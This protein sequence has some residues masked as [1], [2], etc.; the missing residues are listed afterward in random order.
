VY[1]P[2]VRVL[3]LLAIALL[4]VSCAARRAAEIEGELPNDWFLRQR[5]GPAGQIPVRARSRALEAASLS[6]SAGTWSQ[7]GP[8]NIGGRIAALAV[9]PNDPNRI[10]LG[11][12]EGGVF[13]SADGGTTWTPKFDQQAV[14]PVGSLAVH[15]TNSSIVY[16]GTGEEGA[17]G[18]SYEGE[19]VF[20][21]TDGGASWTDMG[22][23]EVRRIAKIAIDPLDPQRLFVA[24]GGGAFNK[25]AHRG[26]YRTTD[27]GASWEKVLY[28]ADDSGAAD[29][30]INPVD[31][32]RVF[33]AIW[34]RNRADNENYFGGE[35]S[36]IYR[37]LDGGD[38]WAKLVTGLPTGSLGRIGLAIAPSNP[39]VVYAIIYLTSGSLN[40]IWRSTNG[41][42]T[43]SKVSPGSLPGSFSTYGYYFGQI[44][45]HPTEPQTVFALDLNISRS[46]NGGTSFTTVS[47]GIHVDQHALVVEPSGRYLAGNDGG[48]YRSLNAGSSWFH[49]TTLPISQFYDLC[50]DRLQPQ[51][52]F[53]GTQDNGTLRTI[54]GGTSDWTNVL[55]GD[56]MQC[57]VDPINGNKVYAESQYG[58]INRSTDGGTSFSP[59]TTGI[60]ANDRRNWDTPI[61]VDPVLPS[62]LY[63]G[64]YRMYRTT[65]SA[66]SWSAISADLTNGPPVAAGATGPV[67]DDHGDHP[68]PGTIT[69]IGVSPLNHAVVWAGTDDGNVWVSSTSGSIWTQV[70][71]PG[72]PYW[73]TELAP[74]PFD[75]DGVYLTV[76]GYRSDDRSPYVRVTHD[77]GATWQDLS[78]TLP[79]VPINSIAPDPDWHGRLIVGTDVGAYLSD[80]G[81]LSWSVLGSGM[82]K[83]VVQ[84]LV[85]DEPSRTLFAG[86][87]GRSMYAYDLDQLPD[88]DADCALADPGAF[89]APG[90]VPS[91]GVAK[92]GVDTALLS[93]SSL[94]AA[95][96]PGTVYDVAVGDL[97]SLAPSGTASSTSLTC[98]LA[99]NTTSDSAIRPSGS[100]VYY[101]VRGRNRCGLGSW[102]KDSAGVERASGACP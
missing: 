68:I 77:L 95:A 45:V 94:A 58:A 5:M 57:E 3:A 84:D 19:G 29:V 86:T 11:A 49:A 88:P 97:S 44:R 47:S 35:N 55:G 43:W 61:T 38:T 41:G 98:G 23:A 10:W 33:A 4:A 83:V 28:V 64:T 74:D 82:P 100:G 54:S 56:G 48:F 79:Q 60:N 6:A 71:P 102:G 53:G 92:T 62:T 73:V 65:N 72:V 75:A 50:I 22:L 32:T 18:W 59:A 78:A 31:P 8:L 42:N 70:N 76:S 34:Q 13:L 14:L 25:D 85:L 15:P 63:T 7:A 36:A 1:I 39:Q 52:R 89:A 2:A 9:D 87:H 16:V 12:A 67:P 40:G 69:A 80:D 99:L 24:A 27:G 37:S 26:V 66:V 46:T 81:G 30:A 21:T 91:L 101:L 93:W 20:K 96:G 90:E 17:G 51:H